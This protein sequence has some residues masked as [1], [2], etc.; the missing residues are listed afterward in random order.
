MAELAV[1]L[2]PAMNAGNPTILPFLISKDAKAYADALA[3]PVTPNPYT[4]AAVAA[5]NIFLLKHLNVF[6]K[7]PP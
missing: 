7:N 6:I 4:T 3:F 5:T 1:V 2:V